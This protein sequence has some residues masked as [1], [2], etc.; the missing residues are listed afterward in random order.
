MPTGNRCNAFFGRF[1]GGV[2][3][4]DLAVRV[5]LFRI[6]YKCSLAP[7]KRVPVCPTAVMF[8]TSD[9]FLHQIGCF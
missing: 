3:F 6:M 1:A 7:L 5:G 4:A 2:R 9:V 8:W